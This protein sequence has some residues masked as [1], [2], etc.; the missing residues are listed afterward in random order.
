MEVAI[1][2]RVPNIRLSVYQ[3][4]CMRPN[5][6][7]RAFE[8]CNLQLHLALGNDFSTVLA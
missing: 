8:R 1:D 4:V 2:V 7:V 3:L 5:P 6:H